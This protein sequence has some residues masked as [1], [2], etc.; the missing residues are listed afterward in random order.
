MLYHL[1]HNHHAITTNFN[2]I[3]K[4]VQTISLTTIYFGMVT[5]LSCTFVKNAPVISERG[6][7]NTLWTLRNAFWS[8]QRSIRGGK[9]IK[10]GRKWFHL[11]NKKHHRAC[12]PCLMGTPVCACAGLGLDLADIMGDSFERAVQR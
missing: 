7:T 5:H 10:K 3:N 9:Q 6:G 12:V 2:L 8:S 1:L 11:L 4:Q